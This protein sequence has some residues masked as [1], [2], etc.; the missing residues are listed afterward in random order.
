MAY[1]YEDETRG[2]LNEQALEVAARQVEAPRLRS[3]VLAGRQLGSYKIIVPLG[4]DGM[5]EIWLT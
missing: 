1:A 2:F 4:K 3:S 5:G